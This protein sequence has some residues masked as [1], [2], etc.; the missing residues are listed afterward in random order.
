MSIQLPREPRPGDDLDSAWGSSVVRCLR[1][2]VLNGGPGVVITRSLSGTTISVAAA[3]CTAP[4]EAESHPFK[5][6]DASTSAPAAKVRVVYGQVNSITP[7]IDGTALDDATPPMLTVVT[8]VIFLKVTFDLDG[9][10]TAAIVGNAATLPSDDATH[11]HIT[12][13]SVNVTDGVVTAISQSVTFSLAC[14]R[15]GVS[16]IHFWAV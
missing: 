11:G 7:T 4:A 6:F 2:L 1:M 10:V 12:L 5:V 15:C 13:A 16:Y 3:R 14:E 9:I 8:G